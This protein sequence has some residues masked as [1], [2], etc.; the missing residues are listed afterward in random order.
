M[1]KIASI[2]LFSV[3][4]CGLAFAVTTLGN[5]IRIK[6]AVG[7]I[8]IE[9]ANAEAMNRGESGV[10]IITLGSSAQTA[11]DRDVHISNYDISFEDVVT[12]FR[13]VQTSKTRTNESIT[14]G[15]TAG[16]LTLVSQ[17]GT[18]HES[19]NPV[20]SS[21]SGNPDSAAVVVNGETT[22]NSVTIDI[23]YLG[24]GTTVEAD[25]VLATFSSVWYRQ[26]DLMMYDGDYFADITL[27][28]T[29]E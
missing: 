11:G 29:I 8:T 28:Y 27:E 13:I 9:K 3:L 26:E 22:D 12:Y 5:T 6:S 19:A 2:L 24:G 25:T 4:L 14:L 15:V 21:F 7:S 23:N 17:D 1:K 10:F 18:I 20:F 16:K